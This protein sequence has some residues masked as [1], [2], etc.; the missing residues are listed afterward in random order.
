MIGT[1]PLTPN[2]AGITG[3][4]NINSVIAHLVELTP[5]QRKQFA[6]MHMD[7]T[8]LLSTVKYVD[9]Q[10]SKQAAAK[11]AQ[12]VGAAPPPVN[13]QVVAQMAP[14]PPV[15]QAAPQPQAT[16]QPQGQPLP[17]DV[18]IGQLPAPNMQG[19]AA[20]GIVAF[21]EG[22]LNPKVFADF[23][24]TLGKTPS[25]FANALPQERATIQQQYEAARSAAN[26][27]PQRVPVS[28]APA[29]AAAAAEE[30]GLAYR[31]GQAT[32]Q[33][34]N[35]VGNAISEGMPR[36]GVGLAALLTPANENQN[37]RE[38]EIMAA[39]HGESYK[40]KPYNKKDAEALLKEMNVSGVTLKDTPAPPAKAKDD[41]TKRDAANY[42]PVEA[43][44]EK[45]TGVDQLRVPDVAPAPAVAPT[46]Q[47]SSAPAASGLDYNA[48]FSSALKAEGNP[49]DNLPPEIAE[50]GDLAR[51]QQTK[52][53][54][55]A[56]KQSE[57]L[58]ALV[59]ARQ[60]RQDAR[61][62]NIAQ[63]EAM[64][65]WL[66]MIM[67]GLET[68]QSTGKGISGIAKGGQSAVTQYMTEAKYTN[69]QRQK[70]DDARDALQELKYNGETMTN[71]DR[72]AAENAMT[73][74]LMAVKDATVKHIAHKEE[75]NLKTA[76]H[77]FDAMVQRDIETQREGH[78]ERVEGLRQKF[79]SDIHASDNAQRLAI[80]RM[81]VGAA[82]ARANQLPGEARTLMA[83][84]G[85]DLKRGM[86]MQAAIA[87]GKFNPM[88]AYV[89]Y[90][91]PGV[92][93]AQSL[94]PSVQA[95]SF[96]QFKAMLGM[97][98]TRP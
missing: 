26:A 12:M 32:R 33:G 85:G 11:A 24:K 6:Q 14:Q 97:D 86:E 60:A 61:E 81:E 44:P 16:Q 25:D 66:A 28:A 78:Q 4:M 5:G 83:L 50:I 2:S 54:A 23:L 40:G 37:T 15:R 68:A 47:A 92:S 73:Q 45:K 41:R 90:Y 3:P 13:Q 93:K 94:D 89:Q 35:R 55:L 57:G 70:L 95:K 10:I 51:A 48:A 49:R 69:A 46:I 9:D 65:P 88:N 22:G 7:D 21:A 30:P 52:A 98:V 38:D 91:L 19:M 20:G 76:G 62:Q 42:T 74:G 18:G 8:M 67:G 84:G 53:M 63:Q 72:L 43:A 1:R 29:Q 96:D 17:E 58:N 36:L 79:E 82:N 71:K 39:I 80:A 64:N 77:K 87:A 27:G 59:S 31:L 34:L 75:L 56:D